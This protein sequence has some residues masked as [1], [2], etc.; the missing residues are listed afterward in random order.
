MAN[1]ENGKDFAFRSIKN[2]DAHIRYSIRG[3][4]T[5]YEVINEVAVNFV[6]K[7]TNI[8]D[9]GCS[10][11]TLLQELYMRD[12]TKT[13][14][15][16]SYVG[17]DIEKNLLPTAGGTKNI[18]FFERDITDPKLVF[19]NT[20][21]ILSIFTLQFLTR[22]ERE[23]IVRKAYE[24]LNDGG[25]FIVAEKIIGDNGVEEAIL[26]EATTQLKRDHFTD[27]E[28]LGKQNRLRTIMNPLT[29]YDN[30]LLFSTVGFEQIIT[31]WQTLNFKC[32]LLIK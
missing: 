18:N 15:D 9:I 32:W 7:G 4:D 16:A 24:S 28:L 8:Y 27:T 17:Y 12:I 25:A 21:L 20:D 2:F 19:F 14:A 23:T 31:I 5:L 1:D 10:K 30:E 13:K 6:K 29:D 3:F 26:S 11:G 22:I